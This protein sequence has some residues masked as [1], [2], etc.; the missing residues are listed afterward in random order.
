MGGK[1]ATVTV[2]PAAQQS[3][4][5]MLVI[6]TSGSM[7]AT[8]MGTVRS[9]VREFL[10]DVPKDVKVGVV[11]FASTAGVDVAPT[12]DHA[13]VSREV[14]SLRSKGETALYAGDP[15]SP[16]SGLGTKGERSIVL[17]SDGGDTVA[18]IEGGKAGA[19]S[20]RKA[21]LTALKRAKVRAEV[22]AFKSPESNG[23]VLKQ[24]AEAGGGSVANA[25]RPPGRQRRLHVPRLARWSRRPCSTIKRP[26]GVIGAQELVVTGTAGGQPFEARSALDLGDVAPVIVASTPTPATQPIAVAAG[27]ISAV[28]PTFLIPSV[29]ILTLGVFLLMT[30]FSGPVFRS[31]RK[32]RVAAIEAVRPRRARPRSSASRA[33]DRHQRAAR[34]HGRQGHGGSRVD[35]QDDGPDGPRRPA[36]AGRRVVRAAHRRGGHRRGRSAS[37]CSGR[38]RPSA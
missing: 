26:A 1:P 25:E 18:E 29:A 31:R 8:G 11:S 30:A 28:S 37:S 10:S 5:T 23:A 19:A 24:F 2:Q 34:A 21:A 3:R 6:D 38:T 17:L 14:A 4:S 20:E 15:G 22:V 35:H 32:E 13:K 36:V 16:S 33:A 9:A 7:G 12:T 27:P